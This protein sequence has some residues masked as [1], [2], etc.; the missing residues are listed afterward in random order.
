M[1]LDCATGHL[2]DVS[3]TVRVHATHGKTMCRPAIRNGGGSL[4][5]LEPSRLRMDYD[6]WTRRSHIRLV[7]GLRAQILGRKWVS[8][9]QRDAN[10]DSRPPSLSCLSPQTPRTGSRF[11]PVCGAR[12]P[13]W[14]Q[15]LHRANPLQCRSGSLDPRGSAQ[16]RAR[17]GSA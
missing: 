11:P 14:R 4:R 8:P 5:R 7:A 17:Q 13:S 16:L 1:L 12:R 9:N 3:D 6:V 10:I 15:S 2:F